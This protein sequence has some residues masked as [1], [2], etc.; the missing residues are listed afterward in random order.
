MQILRWVYIV[1]SLIAT[2]IELVEE[3]GDGAEK[4]KKAI[5]LIQGGL[6]ILAE[7]RIIPKW[8]AGVFSNETFLGWLIDVMVSLANNNGFFV[9]TEAV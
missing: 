2:S 7:D 5:G 8:L 3:P 9:K 6:E 1:T 4:K